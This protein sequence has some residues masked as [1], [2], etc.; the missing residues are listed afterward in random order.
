MSTHAHVSM[1]ILFFVTLLLLA[2]LIGALSSQDGSRRKEAISNIKASKK[3]KKRV[4][5]RFPKN[6]YKSGFND[7]DICSGRDFDCGMEVH[8]T[9]NRRKNKRRKKTRKNY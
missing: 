8:I 7:G 9:I 1:R 2:V 3:T 6:G 4:R 5:G